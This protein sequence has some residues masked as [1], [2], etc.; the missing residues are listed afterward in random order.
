MDRRTDRQ[1]D[2]QKEKQ[3]ITRAVQVQSSARAKRTL[4]LLL[5][6]KSACTFPNSKMR[7]SLNR[8]HIFPR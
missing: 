1:S 4:L 5:L 2:G 6:A 3:V 7:Y 8:T